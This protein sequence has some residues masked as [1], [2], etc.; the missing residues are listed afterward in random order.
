MGGRHG[1]ASGCARSTAGSFTM[2]SQRGF[3]EITSTSP[4][5]S[6]ASHAPFRHSRRTPVPMRV[7]VACGRH[8]PRGS[9]REVARARGSHE[10]GEDQSILLETTVGQP[11]GCVPATEGGPPRP[12]PRRPTSS[13]PHRL[14]VEIVRGPRA[15]RGRPGGKPISDVK[16]RGFPTR[17]QAS[18]R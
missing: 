17:R 2:Q 12:L 15:R 5:K 16:R 9:H 1:F 13:K 14:P 4:S 7:R 8:S 6:C 11:P 10:D 18:A 3:S